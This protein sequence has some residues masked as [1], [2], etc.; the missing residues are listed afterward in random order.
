[1]YRKYLLVLAFIRKLLLKDVNKILNNPLSIFE[2]NADAD[3]NRYL[4]TYKFKFT[5]LGK[6]KFTKFK[7]ILMNDTFTTDIEELLADRVKSGE[8]AFHIDT[9][10]ILMENMPTLTNKDFD[11]HETLCDV[12]RMKVEAFIS[13]MLS[14]STNIIHIFKHW[15]RDQID[16]GKI[17]DIDG[18]VF[19]TTDTL[20]KNC[21]SG[22][23]IY[24]YYDSWQKAASCDLVPFM[25]S[26]R[27]LAK[28]LMGKIMCDMWGVKH[29]TIFIPVNA[30]M[31]DDMTEC[32]TDGLD[33]RRMSHA[34]LSELASNKPATHIHEVLDAFMTNNDFKNMSTMLSKNEALPVQVS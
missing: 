26:S 33:L 13:E 24:K 12:R 20:T 32:T 23:F 21:E 6:V 31:R 1:M 14:S 3:Y 29:E 30:L 19:V 27:S 7:P 4:V 2:N 22:D 8:L 5:I 34:P 18:Y 17:T 9:R 11:N 25:D 10:N 16:N 28:M 15:L